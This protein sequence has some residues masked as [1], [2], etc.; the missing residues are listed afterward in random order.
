MTTILI[1]DSDPTILRQGQK[2]LS[3]DT[4]MTII[5]VNSVDAAFKALANDRIDI[6][7]A[8]YAMNGDGHALMNGLSGHEISVP[9]IFYGIHA[10]EKASIEAIRSGAE[11]FLRMDI[12]P[13]A[14]FIELRG[15]IEEIVRRRQAEA[16]LKRTVKDLKAIVTSNADAMIVL[17]RNGYIQYANP[18]A[19]SLFNI[20]GQ[21]LIG[22]LFGFPIVLSEPVEMYILREFRKFIAVEMRMVEV[23]WKGQPSYLVSIRD[24]TWHVQ[25]EEEL[26]QAK[27]RLEVEVQSRRDELLRVNESLRAEVNERKR[28][29]TALRESERKYRQIVELAQE[30]IWIIDRK[31]T[32]QFVN[33]RLAD[34][35]GFVAEDMAGRSSFE[36]IDA[37]SM[38]TQK[39]AIERRKRGI[40]DSYDCDLV[41]KD[42]T[43]LMTIA[44][45]API[46][47]EDGNY[48]GTLSMFTDITLRRQSEEA[49][50]EAKAQAEL[51]LDLMGHDI[52]NL[53]QI[54][55]GYTELAI[56]MTADE[57]VRSL[58]QKSMDSLTDTARII[59]NVRR[60]Q[61]T[62]SE[63]VEKHTIDLCKV[64]SDLKSVYETSNTRQITINVE[65]PQNC[66]VKA[67]DLVTDIFT[68]LIGNSIKHSSPDKPLVIDIRV[69]RVKEKDTGYLRIT[70]EDNGPG[71]PN[72]LKDKIFLRFQR[73]QTS[74][75]GKGLGLY[76]VRALVDDFGGKV[77]VE[78]RRP[79]DSGRG[80]RFVVVLPAA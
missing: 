6:I 36:F 65:A 61:H 80:A 67:N 76:I 34:M 75:H 63:T 74:A 42:G 1:I 46:I 2:Y 3:Q 25:Q 64:F 7:V 31:A 21:E 10:D 73:G 45:A 56:E 51:Y 13:R 5:P 19:E 41:R 69:A 78:D 79:G 48:A 60:L 66:L 57:D 43:K 62:Q 4:P 49:L 55:M 47:D 20:P 59:D 9:V 8:N 33:P 53:A 11:F 29:E 32:I 18:A 22:K 35:L 40:R 44:S 27:D 39:K 26:S 28:T 24:V 72:W 30:G 58:L 54:G 14:A 12:E 15:L 77:W 68:N 52:R 16:S 70:I 50:K 71:I 17:D 38:E 23:E 37:A